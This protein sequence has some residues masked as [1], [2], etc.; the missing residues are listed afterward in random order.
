MRIAE[1]PAE[2][3]SR[4]GAR[5][6][7]SSQTESIWGALAYGPRHDSARR[8]ASVFSPFAISALTAQ[9]LLAQMQRTLA[10]LRKG[11]YRPCSRN[12]VLAQSPSYFHSPSRPPPD[13]ST[14]SNRARCRNPSRIYRTQR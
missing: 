13:P 1:E 6:R 5:R 3:T 9:R 11:R 8:S 10:S 7:I 12:P 14:G 2:R 4:G